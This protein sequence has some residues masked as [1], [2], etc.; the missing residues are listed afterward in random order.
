MSAFK[1]RRSH[2]AGVERVQLFREMDDIYDQIEH[3]FTWTGNLT[4]GIRTASATSDGAKPDGTV[5]FLKEDVRGLEPGR[6][7]HPRLTKEG[8][9]EQRPLR[10]RPPSS[11]KPWSDGPVGLLGDAVHAMMPNLGRGGCQ[12][13][14]GEIRPDQKLRGLRKRSYAGRRQTYRNRRLVRSASVRA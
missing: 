7:P 3:K 4:N 14:E 1:R 2:P 13:I 5:P 9:I 6:A 10:R 8:E 11:I 12:A